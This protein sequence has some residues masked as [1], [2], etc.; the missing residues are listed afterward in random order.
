MGSRAGCPSARILRARRTTKTPRNE[1]T[2]VSS[3]EDQGCERRADSHGDAMIVTDHRAT[4]LRTGGAQ[5]AEGDFGLLDEEAGIVGRAQARSLT[6]RAV[7]IDDEIARAAHQVMVV[8]ADPPF[9]PCHRTGRL[10]AADETDLGEGVERVV[11]RL[12]GD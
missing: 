10:D 1:G 11:D 5:A 4:G 12:M 9:V 7:D 3:E 8:V 2:E 6:D